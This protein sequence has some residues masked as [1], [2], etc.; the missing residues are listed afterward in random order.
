M[1]FLKEN[2]KELFLSGTVI[3]LL[4][5]RSLWECWSPVNPDDFKGI[6]YIR[7]ILLL[8][9][10]SLILGYL[11]LNKDGFKMR[12]N[13]QL[14]N[15][16]EKRGKLLTVSMALL[17]FCL[18]SVINIG[19]YKTCAHIVDEANYLFQAKI[20]ASGR[21]AAP[22]APLSKEFFHL[23]YFIQSP[24]KWYSSFFPGQSILLALGVLL[25]F[26]F[27]VN[28]LLTAVLLLVTIWA[29]RKLYSISTGI[30]AGFLL[31]CSPFVL[32]QGASYFSHIFPAVLVTVILVWF[33]K[34]DQHSPVR[35]FSCGLLIGV[36]FLFR[37]LSAAVVFLF[38][39]FFYG[40]QLLKFKLI[41]V[42][43]SFTYLVIFGLGV[44]PG[45]LLLLGYNYYLSGHLFTTPHE[46]ALPQEI[47]GLG[48]H[49]M[50]N[51]FINLTGLSVDLLGLPLLSLLPVILFFIS[52]SQ[53]AKFFLIF[54]VIY[55]SAYSLYPYHGLSYGPRF[56]FELVPILLIGST[57][58][59]LQNGPFSSKVLTRLFSNHTKKKILVTLI[60]TVTTISFLGI[61]PARVAVFSKRG[62][63]YHIENMVKKEVIP[64]AVV[65]IMSSDKQR[66]IPYLAGFQLNSPTWKGDIIFIRYRPDKEDELRRV[67]PERKHYILDMD[68]KIVFSD[69]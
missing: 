33:L 42:Q 44:L 60:I 46:L 30:I 59:V 39:L 21:L 11:F 1:R 18:C 50:K 62:E 54:T 7:D 20:F 15:W 63:Y 53:Y 67:Y 31:L 24:D 48:I 36:L 5:L 34:K 29:G 66:L 49:S 4:L 17:I 27:L 2:I 26:P 23:L 16:I 40:F 51:T 52:G 58:V 65:S 45:V 43:F 69:T 28:P 13:S 3:L 12:E 32:F 57:R 68:R 25:K 61:L 35:L 47:L 6:L 22:P 55:I 9:P 37:P 8:F 64:P 10:A 56:Y 19:V 38:I 41:R 14:F